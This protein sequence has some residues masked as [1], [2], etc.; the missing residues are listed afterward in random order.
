MLRLTPGTLF[1]Y[2]ENM[3]VFTV[4]QVVSATYGR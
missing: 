3:E 1:A 2:N 4:S